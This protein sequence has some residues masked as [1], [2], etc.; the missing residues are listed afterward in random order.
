MLTLGTKISGNYV[1]SSSFVEEAPRV[2][3]LTRFTTVFTT[4]LTTDFTTD[5]GTYADS[6]SFVE[7]APRVLELT[8]SARRLRTRPT[9]V[10]CVSICTFVQVKQVKRAR[11]HSQRTTSDDTSYQRLLRQYLYFCTNKASKLSTTSARSSS[12]A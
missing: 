7:E 6:A 5:F 12:A 1:D 9:S 4:D 3:E 11:V 8:R 2:L 10:F